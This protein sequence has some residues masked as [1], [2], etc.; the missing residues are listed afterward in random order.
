MRNKKLFTIAL[1][2]ITLFCCAEASSAQVTGDAPAARADAVV[3]LATSE[4]AQLVKGQWRYSDARIVEVEHHAPG[5]DFRASGPPNRTFDITPKAGAADYDDSRW[6][7]IDATSLD[8]R[9]G[10]GRL[11]FNWYRI[12]LTVPE[13]VGSFDTT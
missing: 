2:L 11:S 9:R 6:E 3:N 13:R 10:N 12:K 5:P 4:G 1:S 8:R 7:A